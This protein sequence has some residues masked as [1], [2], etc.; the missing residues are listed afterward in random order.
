MKQLREDRGIS[1]TENSKLFA[2]Q[3]K[4]LVEAGMAP[5]KRKEEYSLQEAKALI[6]AMYTNFPPTS[7][8][9]IKK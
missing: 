8:E 6:D 9:M 7:A 4:A 2:A 5:N 3:F 1:A